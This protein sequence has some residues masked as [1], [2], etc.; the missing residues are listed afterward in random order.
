M[1]AHSLR[2]V[3]NEPGMTPMPWKKKTTP[4]SSASTAMMRSARRIALGRSLRR[5]KAAAPLFERRDDR[6]K[7]PALR[8]QLVFDTRWHLRMN[9]SREETELLQIA[10]PHRQHLWRSGWDQPLKVGKPPRSL[11]E[12]V[13]YDERPFSSHDR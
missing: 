10:Q 12:L 5:P 4:A 1:T 7:A 9:R 2:P 6:P 11:H 13:Q 8:S 3:M